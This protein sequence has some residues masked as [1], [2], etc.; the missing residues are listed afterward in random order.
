[1]TI[2]H[3]LIGLIL[4]KLFG[5][6]PAFVAGAVIA[7]IDHLFML[8]KNG[9]FGPREIF[10]AMKNEDKYG[11]RYKTPYTHSLLACLVFSAIVLSFNK[12]IGLAFCAGYLSHLLIDLLD[13]D[14]MRLFY[15]SRFSMRGFLPI[16]SYW[17]VVSGAILL[18]VYYLI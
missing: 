7:D 2:V 18:A 14:E 9:H 16:F 12:T 11:E 15:P 10:N 5:Y 13:K 17:E 6:T 3:F 8:F 1:M 4:G